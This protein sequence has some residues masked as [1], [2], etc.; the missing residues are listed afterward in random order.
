MQKARMLAEV[1]LFG[2]L[3]R[4]LTYHIPDE[5]QSEDLIGRRVIVPLAKR[6]QLGVLTAINVEFEGAT[7]A[8]DSF[9]D[10]QPVVSAQDLAMC[11]FVSEYYLSSLGDTI[12]ALLPQPLTSQLSQRVQIVSR[13]R[14]AELAAKGNKLAEFIQTKSRGRSMLAAHH[15]QSYPR[16][17]I[18]EVAA[19][20]AIEIDWNVQSTRLKESDYQ[21]EFVEGAPAEIELTG[22]ENGALAYLKEW[23]IADLTEWRKAHRLTSKQVHDMAAAGALR[24]AEKP[25]FIEPVKQ[26]AVREF[27]ATPAQ[28]K[29]I[30][31]MTEAISAN[32]FQPFLL[33]GVTGS[34]KTEVY[35]A[36][37][38]HAVRAG[39]Q[40]IVLVPEIGLA[41]AI[42]LRLENIF[43]ASLGL[44]HSRLTA[45]SRYEIWNKARSGKLQI[46]LGPRS[47][48]FTPFPSLGLIVVDEE[49]DGAYKQES[50]AP[51]YNARDLAV[52][53]AQK[54]GAVVVLGSATPSVESYY[55]ATSGKYALLELPE[56]VDGRSLPA[57]EIVD[58][59]KSF[60]KKGS[61]YLSDTLIEGI[62][63]ALEQK[64]QVMLLLNRR[65]FAPSVHC[66]SC[67]NKLS[68]KN[69]AV[70]LVYH[71]G[72]N[73]MLC[74]MC[75][76][77]ESYPDKCPDCK[78]NLFLYRGIGTEK[79]EE[80]LR[81]RL[82]EIAVLRMDLDS[83]R[84]Q[85]SFREIYMKFKSGAAKMLLGTQMIS[86]GFDF[87]DVAL[88]GIITADTTLELPDFRARER[89]F[90]LLTQASGRAGRL[91]FPGKVIL[92]TLHPTDPTIA[93][94]SGHDFKGFYQSEIRDREDLRFPP[95]AHLILIAIESKDASL[96]QRTA[97]D[98][99]EQ[100]PK[101]LGK[102]CSIQGPIPAPIQK[103]KELFR[104]HLLLKTRSVRRVTPI[105][106][107]IV[108]S[109]EIPANRKVHVIVDV[110]PVDMM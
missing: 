103:L 47:A 16:S 91:N 104:F 87:P 1:C 46:V 37:I 48:I 98:L 76:R 15:L 66:Y 60:E 74:H 108:N 24:I 79:M 8:I 12:R 105:I 13:E 25:P 35:V 23:G 102:L 75:G 93:L 43:G 26:V 51:R 63:S 62:N 38:Q 71:K 17:A 20:G 73:R 11:R 64:G 7:R 6:K 100:L 92:Q 39:K 82:P 5:L 58:L 78:S 9:P 4:P 56:R 44:I 106:G 33:H 40:A 27:V 72:R 107:E 3:K 55:N 88:V 99:G 81:R 95:F 41:Q 29:A 80:E 52:Y 19:S 77:Q 22:R 69:C 57:V 30:G 83:T 109:K 84:K 70:A 31:A 49:H 68:C 97:I 85:G 14:L 45:R 28:A 96:A 101:A 2:S 42:Y 53:R 36:A 65:G 89:A 110:D 34:G 90:Q 21:V 54:L 18:E 94:A 61:G 59:K 86:K 10:L 50:P 67:G 32:K